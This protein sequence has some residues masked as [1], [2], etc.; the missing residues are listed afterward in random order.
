MQKTKYVEVKPSE[1]LP[2]EKGE[3]I[4]VIDPESNFAS[5]YSFDPEDPADVEW[6]KETPEYWLEERPDYEDEMKKAL[7]ETKDSLYNYAGSMDQIELVEKIESLLT[8]LK[9]ES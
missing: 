6:W 3:Y 8:K 2:A 4:A 5:F 9:T 1:R 7:E